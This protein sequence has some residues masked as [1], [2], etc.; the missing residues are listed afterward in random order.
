[1]SSVNSSYQTDA[2]LVNMAQGDTLEKLLSDISSTNTNPLW[3]QMT[4][5]NP[6]APNPKAIPHVWH[7]DTLRP[8]LVR[9]GKLVTEKQAERRVLL[10]V[11]PTMSKAEAVLHRSAGIANYY[12]DRCTAHHRYNQCRSPACDA[13]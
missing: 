9:A 13:K 4:K 10:L 7:Y 8:C 11:N 1:M 5:L 2:T 3:N 6:P 12:P